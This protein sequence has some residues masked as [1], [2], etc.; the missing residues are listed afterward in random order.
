MRAVRLGSY[1]TAATRAGIANL[2]RRKSMRRYCRLWPPPC[3]RVVM[4]PLLLRPPVRFSGSS[5]DFSGS[6]FVTSVKSETER[7]RVAGVI[8][9]NCRM[10][11][12]ALE[13]LDGVALFEGDDRFLPG[14]PPAGVPPVR[15]AFGAHDHGAHA[16]DGHLE[17]RLDGRLDLRL[18]C[19]RMD[20]ERVF[21]ARAV[22]RRRFLRHDGTDNRAVQIRHC[23]P[24][25]YRRLRPAP[26]SLR[27][28]SAPR[29]SRT[30][31]HRRSA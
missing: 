2:S 12:S 1:S 28:P 16:G 3:Q 4:W 5:S 15:A 17:Q 8:G 10:P 27:P 30:P 19:V 29:E 7:N 22:R 13:Y 6:V 14:R 21:L 31:S 18:A 26:R 9:R 20:A 25:S 23:P 11:I 24:P